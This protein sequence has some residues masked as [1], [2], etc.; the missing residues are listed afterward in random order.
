VGEEG[1]AGRKR[2]RE[3]ERKLSHQGDLRTDALQI[4]FPS[5]VFFCRQV[6]GIPAK[7]GERAGEC[8]ASAL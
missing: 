3:R 1:G 7:P 2:E 5:S 6:E 8:D 4:A